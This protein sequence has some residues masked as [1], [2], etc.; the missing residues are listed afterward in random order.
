[1][2]LTVK[3]VSEL[4]SLSVGCVYQLI[5]SGD[6]PAYRFGTGRGTIRIDEDDAEALLGACR[7]TKRPIRE[8]G[9]DGLLGGCRTIKGPKHPP[10]KS[11]RAAEVAMSGVGR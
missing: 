5:R 7:T 9:A 4:W 1:M 8:D 11:R 10:L 2:M 3:Q 6:L